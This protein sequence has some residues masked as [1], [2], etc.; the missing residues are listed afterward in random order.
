MYSFKSQL[1]DEPGVENISVDTIQGVLKYKRPGADTE[2]KNN[3][4]APPSALR[5]IELILIDEASQ[6]GDNEFDRLYKSWKEQPH[7]PMV[8]IVADF[9]QL[10]P[11]DAAT[12]Q[13]LAYHVCIT[14]V[15]VKLD[16]VYRS[17]DA[18]HLVFLNR[19]RSTQPDRKTLADYFAERR[20]PKQDHPH[21]LDKCVA[22]GMSIA[23]L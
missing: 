7:R 10:Q 12:S 15:T 4:W 18:E 22:R 8:V 9:Q 23:H 17:N 3:A 16:T 1:P 11:V 20:W 21:S 14:Q 13:H 19:I 2:H 6:Y 5:R